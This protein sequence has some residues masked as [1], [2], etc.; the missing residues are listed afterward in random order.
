MVSETIVHNYLIYNF[1]TAYYHVMLGTSMMSCLL[2]CTCLF[3]ID[4]NSPRFQFF[5]V[6][7]SSLMCKPVCVCGR[8]GG[9]SH[10]KKVDF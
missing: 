3:S 9:E 1:Y 6:S 7:L 2:Q 4:H 5:G 10:L 8:G